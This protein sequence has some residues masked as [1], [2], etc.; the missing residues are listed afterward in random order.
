MYEKDPFR[1]QGFDIQMNVACLLTPLDP[2]LHDGPEASH[3]LQQH[4]TTG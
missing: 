4:N 3:V 1:A 2:D